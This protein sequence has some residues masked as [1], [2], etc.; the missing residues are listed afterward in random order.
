MNPI[1]DIC[2]PNF[3]SH[4]FENAIQFGELHALLKSCSPTQLTYLIF[5]YVKEE[6]SN[7]I[8]QQQF[9]KKKIFIVKIIFFNRRVSHVRQSIT[10]LRV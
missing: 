5:T 4:V 10:R 9:L 1:Q 7:Y 6:G 3:V 8:K 2:I